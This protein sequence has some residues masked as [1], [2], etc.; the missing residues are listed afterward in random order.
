MPAT[1]FAIIVLIVVIFST[2]SKKQPFDVVPTGAPYMI[3]SDDN[4]QS[5]GKGTVWIEIDCDRPTCTSDTMTIVNAARDEL[6]N[7]VS[8]SR[9]SRWSLKKVA[10]HELFHWES[11]PRNG[12]DTYRVGFEIPY[13]AMK[14]MVLIMSGK[15]NF[16]TDKATTKSVKEKAQ[17]L[18]FTIPDDTDG[19]VAIGF[20]SKR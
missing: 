15:K 2:P 3:S 8:A 19:P 20:G 18:G 5:S 4:R 16:L 1:G 17:G 10:P 6:T 9:D 12:S 7:Y 13:S 14:G 11:R